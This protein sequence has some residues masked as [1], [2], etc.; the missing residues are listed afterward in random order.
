MEDNVTFPKW[1]SRG[2]SQSWDDESYKCRNSEL[3]R[4]LYANLNNECEIVE[5]SV[6]KESNVQ[7]MVASTD[8]WR[9]W[10]SWRCSIYVCRV[11]RS[12]KF[13]LLAGRLAEA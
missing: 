12:S 11:K 5:T 2:S 6:I 13:T 3:H 9:F 1:V 10:S 4:G 7:N 8:E